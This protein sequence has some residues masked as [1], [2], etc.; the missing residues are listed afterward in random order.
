[1]TQ[2]DTQLSELASRIDSLS[3]RSL[4][5][6]FWACAGALLPEFRAWAAHRGERTE[7]ILTEALSAAYAFAVRVTTPPQALLAALEASTPEGDSPDE[8]PSTAAQDCWICAD[9]GIRVPLDPSYDAGPAIEYALEPVLVAVTEEL[10][11]V[12]QLGTSDEEEAQ[13]AALLRH[14][15]VAAA[16]EF[17]R[18]A[19]D[20]LQDQP[21]PNEADLALVSS[22]AVVLAPNHIAASDG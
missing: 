2:L 20:F 5:G 15:K 7:P 3:R 21:E 8:V 16:V 4:A 6:L 19:T 22:R 10:F 18:W 12:S 9:I 1:M 17:C 13:V 11:G 14:P